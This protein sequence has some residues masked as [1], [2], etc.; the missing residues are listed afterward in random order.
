MNLFI[1][2]SL[3]AFG[4]YA[5]HLLKQYGESIKRKETFV[6]KMLY[7]SM[8]MNVLS[9]ILLV[10]IGN[11]LPADLIVMSP[12]TCV[13]I[14]SFGASMLSGF[15][16][17]KKPTSID[18]GDTEKVIVTDSKTLTVEPDPAKLTPKTDSG[19]I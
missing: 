8:G 13:I 9:I 1:E 12:L 18:V 14:G 4:G 10:Y 16:N 7:V 5:F 3:L 19:V 11:R 2:Q 6:N 15:I 17:I